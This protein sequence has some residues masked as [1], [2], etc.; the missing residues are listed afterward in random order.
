MQRR[1]SYS[2]LGLVV[3]ISIFICI[4]VKSFLFGFTWVGIIWMLLSCVYFYVSWRR[5]SDSKVVK[6]ATTLFLVL[7]AVAL[8]GILLF[9]KNARPEMHAFEGTGDTIQDAAIVEE[10]PIVP[11]YVMEP[12]DTLM[13]DTLLTD[14]M[15]DSLFID[16]APMETSLDSLITQQ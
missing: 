5:P 14:E 2:D 15:Q 9:D 6:H 12:E 10:E 7:S 11:I 16:E 1:N 13:S 8:I 4:L 3:A